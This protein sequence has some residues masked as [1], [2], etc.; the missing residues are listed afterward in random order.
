METFVGETRVVLDSI[1]RCGLWRLHIMRK[2]A[3]PDI[4]PYIVR[5]TGEVHAWRYEQ[6]AGMHH[7][8]L[9]WK[10]PAQQPDERKDYWE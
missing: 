3:E 1:S 9:A 4:M 5:A 2:G 10:V 8:W 6:P 7:L